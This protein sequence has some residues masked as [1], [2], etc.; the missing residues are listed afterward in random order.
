MP[1]VTGLAV[2]W[3][4]VAVARGRKYCFLP[5]SL[6]WP[7]RVWLLRD[8]DRAQR[9]GVVTAWAAVPAGLCMWASFLGH[10]AARRAAAQAADGALNGLSIGLAGPPQGR[11]VGGVFTVAAGLVEE[12]TLTVSPAHHG[13]Y[14]GVV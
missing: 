14:A 10:A 5:G 6:T 8:H 1:T 7:D 11:M 9:I 3:D 13:A 4:T 12:V 2:P